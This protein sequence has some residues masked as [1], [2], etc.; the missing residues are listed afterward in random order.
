M[1]L[2]R[3][4]ILELLK[5]RGDHNRARQAENDFPARVDTEKDQ[6]LLNRFGI[7]PRD[8]VGTIGGLDL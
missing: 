1:Q 8:L 6:N 2:D 4:Q 3:A 7:D 5:S